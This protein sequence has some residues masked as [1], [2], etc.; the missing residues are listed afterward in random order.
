MLSG[1]RISVGSWEVL[2]MMHSS[3]NVLIAPRWTENG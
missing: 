1:N 2:G 3:V